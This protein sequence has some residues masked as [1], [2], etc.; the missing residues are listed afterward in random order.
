MNEEETIK[1]NKV[2]N[3]PKQNTK[4]LKML[5]KKSKESS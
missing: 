5:N 2:E 4:E 1:N 3:E